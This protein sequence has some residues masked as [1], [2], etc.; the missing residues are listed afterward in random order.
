VYQKK[1]QVQK[2]NMCLSCPQNKAH[3]NGRR[4]VHALR[5]ATRAAAPVRV[6]AVVAVDF[7]GAADFVVAADFVDA[8]AA[9]AVAIVYIYIYIINI[10]THIYIQIH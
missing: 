10:C 4:A 3:P 7:V 8:A 1:T 6:A 9:R 2:Q 5:F